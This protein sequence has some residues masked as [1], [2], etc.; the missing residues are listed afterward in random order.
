MNNS[1]KAKKIA[2]KFFWKLFL[3]LLVSFTAIY[4]SEATG[5]YEFEQ[6]NKKELIEKEIEKF[7]KD[8]A[9]GKNVDLNEYINHDKVNYANKLSKIGL[10][11]SN[12][13]ED[14]VVGSLESTF[15]FLNNVLG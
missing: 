8:V 3:F 6:Y 5:Y 9:E 11:L 4:I 2:N 12:G 13:I 14:V 7:E 15:K 10:K 1:E